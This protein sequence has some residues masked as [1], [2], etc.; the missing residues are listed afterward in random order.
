MWPLKI[1]LLLLP[2]CLALPAAA[3]GDPGEEP[4]S[5]EIA[6]EELL[7][8]A[9]RSVGSGG[10]G[11]AAL[12]AMRRSLAEDV[13]FADSVDGE[14]AK[15][16]ELRDAL[17]ATIAARRLLL[18]S[19]TGESA[20]GAVLEASR[21][22]DWLL[23]T[24]PSSVQ[25]WKSG[26][27]LGSGQIYPYPPP[28]PAPEKVAAVD[29]DD[30]P[31]K[32]GA[33]L[34]K[35]APEGG[36]A[37]PAADAPKGADAEKAVVPAV[38]AQAEEPWKPPGVATWAREVVRAGE[39]GTLLQREFLLKGHPEIGSLIAASRAPLAYVSREIH[40]LH[41]YALLTG[42]VF[43]YNAPLTAV[44][45]LQADEHNKAMQAD[46]PQSALIDGG[47]V[48][49]KAKVV[50]RY[51]ELIARHSKRIA[52]INAQ[53]DAMVVDL[54]T[55]K[56]QAALLAGEIEERRRTLSEEGH[57]VTEQ[58]DLILRLAQARETCATLD[59]MLL[60]L[61]AL[62]G[63]T[64]LKLLR[65]LLRAANEEGS[66]A[67]SVHVRYERALQSLRRA[68]RLDRLG[69]DNRKMRRWISAAKSRT[70]GEGPAAALRLSAYEA[71]LDL[72]EVVRDTVRRR[73]LMT[74]RAGAQGVSAPMANEPSE[75]TPPEAGMRRLSAMVREP[76][77]ANWDAKFVELA[78]RELNDPAFRAEFDADLVAAHYA[79]VDDR[80]GALVR[81]YEVSR[82]ES[83]L[84]E[85]YRAGL[86]RAQAALAG[87]AGDRW[88]RARELPAML[89]A[90]QEDF[91]AAMTGI[92]EQREKNQARLRLLV[93]YRRDLRDLGTRSLLIRVD[94]NLMDP[95]LGHALRGTRAALDS[96]GRW[97]SFQG[98]A[99][100]G[101]FLRDSWKQILLVMAVL[102]VAFLFAR[103][104]RRLVDGWIDRKVASYPETERLSASVRE[105][106]MQGREARHAADLAVAQTSEEEV[107]DQVR[108][109]EGADQPSTEEQPR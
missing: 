104:G 109:V 56:T 99:H 53:L 98:D 33:G 65:G 80:I 84:N 68:R 89:A 41:R 103:G 49:E 64:R 13:R 30:A 100:A 108:E 107:L 58:G 25:V 44:R 37:S 67:E 7:R 71:L 38:R 45:T 21:L 92:T 14:N 83:L 85:R 8:E 73:G 66:A 96:A 34:G 43:P 15:T 23:G 76:G 63:A 51:E 35:S 106:R 42:D 60:Y 102:L 47:M 93:S 39:G 69:G 1:F 19:E 12:E 26:A 4:G 97:V 74:T 10:A 94:R 87:L 6:R 52:A 11:I 95:Y 105:E 46:Q 9:Q 31:K 61:T 62:R 24:E 29:S 72:N 78:E 27:D 5:D 79:A 20:G 90:L 3:G 28:R 75:E 36:A 88:T 55:W 82:D 59:I 77:K 57:T 2:L 54:D 91:T 17:L 32:E 40:D 22:E 18:G 81:A 50:A 101:S 86:G 16:R 48:R 70:P